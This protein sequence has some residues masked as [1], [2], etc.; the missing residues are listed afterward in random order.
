MERTWL[1][2]IQL[3]GL[4]IQ[5]GL[6]LGMLG[7][8]ALARWA[9]RLRRAARRRTPPLMRSARGAMGPLTGDAAEPWP[10]GELRPSH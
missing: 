10:V 5:V 7:L 9:G 2:T 8:E 1:E 6:V 3:L 4:D